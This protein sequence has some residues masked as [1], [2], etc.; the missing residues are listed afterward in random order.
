[1]NERIDTASRVVAASPAARPSKGRPW[2]RPMMVSR[3][4]RNVR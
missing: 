2:A 4:A 1:M 3:T